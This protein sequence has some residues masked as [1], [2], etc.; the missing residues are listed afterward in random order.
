VLVGAD[1]ARFFVPPYVGHHGWL[2]VRLEGDP[3]WDEI[4]GLVRDAYRMTAPKRLS[5]R[6]EREVD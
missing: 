5:A 3:D 6:L 1:P 4:A 2:G